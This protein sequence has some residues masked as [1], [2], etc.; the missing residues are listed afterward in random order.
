[1]PARMALQPDGKSVLFQQEQN[2]ETLWAENERLRAE[3][4]A[5]DA[6]LR[7][8]AAEIEVLRGEK[9]H[10]EAEAERLREENATLRTKLGEPK[11][12]PLNSSVPPSRGQKADGTSVPRGKPRGRRGSARP[13]HPSPTRVENVLAQTCQHC[14]ADVSGVAQEAAETYDHVEIPPIVPDVTRVVLHGGT[15][16]C[17]SKAFKAEPPVGREPGNMFGPRL[18]ALVVL[19]RHVHYV[20]FA[21]MASLLATVFGVT[22]SEGGLANM[23]RRCAAPFA[24]QQE[25]IRQDVLAGKTVES[26]ETTMRVGKKRWQE[27]VFHHGLSCCFVAAKARSK[28]V[29][30]AFLGK[31]RPEAWVSDR[32]GS[33]MGW[34][35]LH[36]VCLAHLLR[37]CQHATDCGDP[38]F[39]R[40]V[41]AL[42]CRAM[43]HH[44]MRARVIARLGPGGPV[45]FR[46]RI[47]AAMDDLLKEKPEHP[48]AAKLHRVM[49]KERQRLFVFLDHPHVPPTNNGSERSLRPGVVFRKV[50]NCFRSEWGAHLHASVSSAIETG[51][52][53]GTGALDAIL[54]TLADEPLPLPKSA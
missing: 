33:Q 18:V 30:E 35:D 15:C 12:T 13:L 27:W 44:R 48:A 20:S 17:C 28:E 2:A 6:E 45:A 32:L 46:H 14:A 51:R 54:V 19:L 9:G 23:L 47:N 22:V 29:V 7:A 24:A 3:N 38:G 42:L 50:T 49:V 4:A 16:P 21:R 34:A 10:L 37:D 11:K 36:Q 26:D 43:R 39:A 25:R 53:R 1:M 5:K 8:K 52:R 41:A 31:V 40:R